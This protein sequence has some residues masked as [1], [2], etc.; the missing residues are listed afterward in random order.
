M[1][2]SF[3]RRSIQRFYFWEVFFP[4]LR[5]STC[6]LYIRAT[7]ASLDMIF[8]G[9]VFFSSEPLSACVGLCNHLHSQYIELVHRYKSSFALPFHS[10]TYFLSLPPSAPDS[11][12][13][14]LHLCNFVMLRMLRL[15]F[16]SF[17]A[18]YNVFEVQL[19]HFLYCAVAIHHFFSF[20]FW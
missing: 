19:G 20:F 3:F 12:W 14:G 13:S 15:I 4:G 7:F 17:F 9:P 2:S 16:F 6:S 5:I 8:L 11:H 18:Q 10:Q 1:S